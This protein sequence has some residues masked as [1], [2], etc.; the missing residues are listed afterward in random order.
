[1]NFHLGLIGLGM[2]AQPNMLRIYGRYGD[3]V[4]AL[5]TACIWK[6]LKTKREYRWFLKR[7]I[8]TSTPIQGPQIRGVPI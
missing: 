6:R 8:P 5:H 2:L 4:T 1:M 3:A 7:E